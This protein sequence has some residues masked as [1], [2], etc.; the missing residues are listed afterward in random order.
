MP[1]LPMR[2]IRIPAELDRE[3][4]ERQGFNPPKSLGGVFL[5]ASFTA[6]LGAVIS[7]FVLTALSIVTLAIYGV[8][9]H[10]IPN[11]PDAYRY[12]GLPGAIVVLLAGWICAFLF[13]RR[14]LK[15]REQ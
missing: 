4:R 6:L 10:R 7:F 8:M 12:V 5:R 14:Q 15:G 11:F 3:E 13:F 2:A 1:S 9:N